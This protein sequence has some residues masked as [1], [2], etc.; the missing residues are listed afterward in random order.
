MQKKILKCRYCKRELP[1][2]SYVTKKGCILCD[3]E[4]W[5][6]KN[7]NESNNSKKRR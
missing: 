4:Y 1:D 5:R 2:K 6:K 7:E 3:A